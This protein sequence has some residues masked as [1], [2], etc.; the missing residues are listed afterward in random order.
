MATT[1]CATALPQR[2]T[3]QLRQRG[4][5]ALGIAHEARRLLYG[6]TVR[7]GPILALVSD[8]SIN[9]FKV[10]DSLHNLSRPGRGLRRVLVKEVPALAMLVLVEL[11]TKG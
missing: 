11:A 3:T 4:S 10:H 9:T 7:L 5:D 2:P 6:L 1:L 8:N